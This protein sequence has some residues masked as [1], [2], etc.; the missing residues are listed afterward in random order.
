MLKL[1]LTKEG[2]SLPTNKSHV[3][4]ESKY[5]YLKSKSVLK[6][7]NKKQNLCCLHYDLCTRNNFH[8]LV[9]IN[10]IMKKTDF[11]KYQNWLIVSSKHH[12]F[13]IVLNPFSRKWLFRCDFL[14]SWASGFNDCS[15]T[16]VECM[17]HVKD[18]QHPLVLEDSCFSYK[19]S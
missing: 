18:C 17:L 3:K 1:K 5:S 16:I 9:N 6:N 11:L 19:A 8:V 7:K 13:L 12:T 2:S 14:S 4:L 10:I 15:V